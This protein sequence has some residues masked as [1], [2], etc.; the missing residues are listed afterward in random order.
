MA[1]P[2]QTDP[3][4]KLR[5]T[6]ELKQGIEKSAAANNRSMN[7]EIL[8]R[9]SRSFWVE[10]RLETQKMLHESSS[11]LVDEYARLYQELK[12]EIVALREAVEKSQRERD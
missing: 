5:L 9:L 8:A 10:D 12:A 7:A 6:P 11:L 3:Q 4:F 1:T 2:R